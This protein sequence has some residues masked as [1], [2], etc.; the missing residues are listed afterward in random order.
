MWIT[1]VSVNQPVFASMVMLALVVLGLVSYRMLPVEQMPEVNEPE[2]NIYISYPGASPEAIESDVIKPIENVINSVEGVKDIFATAREGSAYFNIRFSL[3]VDIVAATQEVRDK[4]AQIKPGLP[5][6]VRD[7]QITRAN[8]DGSQQPVVTLTVFSDRRS[9]REVS[10]LVEQQ[11]IKRL[12]N[13]YGV[14]HIWTG[15]SV[16]RQVQ[17]FL[18]PDAMQSYPVGVDQVIAAIEAA[19]QDLPAGTITHGAT[20]R[21]VRVEGKIKDPRGFE[22]IIVANQG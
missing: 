18:R 5:R 21:L 1:R 19:N 15:G 4:V 13:A 3:D 14:G 16:E 20:E 6:E 17:I 9:L 12:E 11:I 8:S 22:R 7:P 2:V 10:T